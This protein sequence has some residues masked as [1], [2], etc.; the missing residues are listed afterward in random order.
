[1]VNFRNTI[2]ILTSNIGA[3]FI[4]KM[5]KVGFA[6]GGKSADYEEAKAKVTAALKDF[7]RPE[8]LNRLDEIIIFDILSPEAV[9]DIV[10]IQ[11]AQV[12]ERLSA[13][14]ISLSVS[15]DVFTYLAKEG[16][17]PQ[18]G[19]RPLRRLIQSKILNP[20]ATLIIGKGL[21]KGGQV[22]LS[23]KN[24]E[25][26]FDIR[27]GKNGRAKSLKS[28]VVAEHPVEAKK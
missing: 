13:K 24:G 22:S 8:F 23:M 10:K 20:V 7:F 4:D 27:K 15:A 1:M 26:S 25:V 12:E 6:V 3:Q 21:D 11:L 5:E 17:N 28:D 19:A 18:Y 2:I 9:S 16:Y 14:G